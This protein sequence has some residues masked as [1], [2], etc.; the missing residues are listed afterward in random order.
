MAKAQ[1]QPR[2]QMKKTDLVEKLFPTEH[3]PIDDTDDGRLILTDLGNH[4]IHNLA[5][6]G[7]LGCNPGY[8]FRGELDYD[9]PLQTSL[10]RELLKESNPGVTI[11]TPTLKA[12]E[13]KI[14]ERFIK[15]DGERVSAIIDGSPR[16]RE[17]VVWWMSVMQHYRHPTRL[18][19]F[20]TDIRIALFFAVEHYFKFF[21]DHNEPKDLFIYCFPCLDPKHQHDPVNNKTPFKSITAGI[22]MNLALGGEIG[23]E[24]MLARHEGNFNTNYRQKEQQPWGWDRPE[25]ENARLRFQR[26]MFVYP[27]ADPQKDITNGGDSWLVNSLGANEN[28]PFFLGKQFAG[29]P[30][31]RIR[32]PSR[33]ADM[34]KVR[35]K[36]QF[37][38]TPATIYV[39]FEKV[40][41][42][43]GYYCRC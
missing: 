19:D 26:G 29:P 33:Y 40:G 32:I 8:I 28:D 15:G 11:P 4:G 9:C 12:E 35:L 10:E 16:S 31:K 23:L 20:T 43:P 18:V 17:N 25:Y 3:L 36:E 24:W 34:F 6:V 30:A 7:G 14:I 38:L 39:D 21:T 27:Y 42:E 22:D 1:S 41:M 5:Y 13:K 37:S 2:A